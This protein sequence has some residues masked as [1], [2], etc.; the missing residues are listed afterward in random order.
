MLAAN[1]CQYY[2][3]SEPSGTPRA[4]SQTPALLFETFLPYN[5]SHIY[6]VGGTMNVLRQ[7]YR[8]YSRIER[9]REKNEKLSGC[10]SCSLH[11]ASGAGAVGLR[12]SRH[13]QLRY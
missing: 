2:L 11:R 3:D 8:K 5:S 6:I 1:T 13:G 12:A 4:Y 10:F 7:N 9:M